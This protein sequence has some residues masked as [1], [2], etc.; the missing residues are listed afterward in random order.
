MP[1]SDKSQGVTWLGSQLGMNARDRSLTIPFWMCGE[2]WSCIIPS[3]WLTKENVSP[4]CWSA[5]GESSMFLICCF[6]ISCV[7]P[8]GCSQKIPTWLKAT[9]HTIFRVVE[10]WRFLGDPIIT[11]LSETWAGCTA[12]Q[13]G[14]IYFML[15]SLLLDP[16]FLIN[17]E[18]SS[19]VWVQASSYLYIHVSLVWG[20]LFAEW[21]KSSIYI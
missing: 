18:K 6:W 3:S 2:R 4:F 16:G 12:G 1:V 19:R 5:A 10:G 8:T 15:V 7:K 11:L 14:A 17:Q 21:M 20:M 9:R 13:T